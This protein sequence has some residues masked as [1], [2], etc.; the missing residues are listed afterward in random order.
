MKVERISE[1]VQKFNGLSYYKCGQ[2]FQRKGKRLH[3]MVWEY[4]NGEIPEGYHIHHIDHDRNNNDIDNL[5]LIKASDHLQSHM[6]EEERREKSRKLVMKAI[7]AAPEWHRSK[8]GYSWHSKHIKEVWEKQEPR[9]VTCAWC[10]KEFTTRDMAN[11]K[12]RFCCNNHKAAA[13]RWRRKH[14]NSIDYPGRK[15]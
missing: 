12:D 13:L 2:Y 7:E 11:R 15:C 9:T 5:T 14:E 10:G 6:N 1:T 4:H 3:R 8:D